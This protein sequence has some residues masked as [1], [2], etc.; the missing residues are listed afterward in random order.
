MSA[1][2]NVVHARALAGPDLATYSAQE[3]V[4]WFRQ[5]ANQYAHLISPEL[6][7]AAHHI[8]AD[9]AITPL[10]SQAGYPIE[11][12]AWLIRVAARLTEKDIMVVITTRAVVK[13]RTS[14]KKSRR[15]EKPARSNGPLPPKSRS[16]IISASALLQAYDGETA[17]RVT[18]NAVITLEGAAASPLDADLAILTG[19][20]SPGGVVLSHAWELL[21]VSLFAAIEAVQLLVRRAP[22][23]QGRVDADGN[24]GVEWWNAMNDIMC[25][26]KVVEATREVVAQANSLPERNLPLDQR[27][28]ARADR[29]L[30][31]IFA[32]F[33]TRLDVRAFRERPGLQCGRVDAMVGMGSRTLNELV[34]RA[35]ELGSVLRAYSPMRAAVPSVCRVELKGAVDAGAQRSAR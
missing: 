21:Q 30:D 5:V 24:Y 8:L 9:D 6:R 12:A 28:M 20:K 16:I 1:N 2:R 19:E 10:S 22:V 11:A 32:Q 34:E 7:F 3:L 17:V 35:A 27:W 13:K 4:D 31:D 15:K 29:L 25:L 18:R 14:K 26:R 33:G 23:H